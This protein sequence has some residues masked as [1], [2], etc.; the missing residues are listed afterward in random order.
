M[1]AKQPLQFVNYIK[2]CRYGL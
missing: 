1:K 2:V